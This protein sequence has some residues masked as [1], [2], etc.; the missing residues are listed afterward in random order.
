[1]KEHG[2]ALR[3]TDEAKDLLVEQGYDPTMGARP[4]RRAI[5]RMV[6][7]VLSEKIVSG[8]LMEGAKVRITAEDGKLSVTLVSESNADALEIMANPSVV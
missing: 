1:M 7:D 3:L 6:E 2:M 4:L 8:Q 5:Q